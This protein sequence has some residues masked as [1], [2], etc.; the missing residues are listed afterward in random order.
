MRARLA[1]VLAAVL[2]FTASV[3]P[4][5][6]ADRIRR[7]GDVRLAQAKVNATPTGGTLNVPACVYHEEVSI[8]RPM[9]LLAAP[10]ATVDGDNTRRP[11]SWSPRTTSP[12]TA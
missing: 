8:G 1:P 4:G 9:T 7:R 10:G 11:G 5:P 2:A 12:S 3:V 6:R